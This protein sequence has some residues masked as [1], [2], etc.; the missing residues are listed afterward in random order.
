MNIDWEISER[1]D[2]LER[3]VLP[4]KLTADERV[5]MAYWSHRLVC[6][7][8]KLIRETPYVQHNRGSDL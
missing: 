7:G 6:L 1:I 4:I 5:A 3:D 8:I 2:E